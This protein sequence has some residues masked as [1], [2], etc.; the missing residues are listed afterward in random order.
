MGKAQSFVLSTPFLMLPHRA[1]LE[2]K[3]LYVGIGEG[4]GV[5]GKLM[6]AAREDSESH[7]H[8]HMD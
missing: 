2:G 5:V 8:I 6:S 7:K 1:E 4:K 3:S